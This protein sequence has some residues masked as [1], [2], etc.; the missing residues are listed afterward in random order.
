MNQKKNKSE[1]IVNIINNFK[2]DLSKEQ[3]EK[4]Q[5]YVSPFTSNSIIQ[6]LYNIFCLFLSENK[7]S[8]EINYELSII[9][10]NISPLLLCLIEK[11]EVLRIINLINLFLS[12]YYSLKCFLKS[13]NEENIKTCI[14]YVVY[15]SDKEKFKTIC[16]KLPDIYDKHIE[17]FEFKLFKNKEITK[18]IF[19]L[20]IL[21]KY[22]AHNVFDDYTLNNLKLLKIT[23]N[24][25]SENVNSLVILFLNYLLNNTSLSEVHIEMLKLYNKLNIKEID[26]QLYFSLE[27]LLDFFPETWTVFMTQNNFSFEKYESEILLLIDFLILHKSFVINLYNY[28]CE[29]NPENFDKIESSLTEYYYSNNDVQNIIENFYK[30]YFNLLLDSYL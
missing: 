23:L 20:D 18:I 16:D 22:I 8:E 12:K 29:M 26:E 10:K 21:L 19:F 11:Y 17:T 5:L 28:L 4:I 1:I 7:T 2:N 15:D 27:I 25:N 6:G 9:I 24:N 14:E 13:I 30:K 3:K